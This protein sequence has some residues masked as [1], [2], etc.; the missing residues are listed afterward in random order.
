MKHLFKIV[1]L[2]LLAFACNRPSNFILIQTSMG[3]ITVELYDETPAHR[4]NFQ[5]LVAEG[6]YEG[7]LFHRVIEDFMIQGGDPDSKGA[8]SS[9]YLGNGG[10]GYTI[11]AELD[12]S[13][14]CFHKKGALAAART[15]DAANP[16]RVSSGSQFYIVSGRK[17]TES[18]ISQMERR[19]MM[20]TRREFFE[21]LS[22]PYQQ[23][24]DSLKAIEDRE[25]LKA[26]QKKVLAQAD[27]KLA[28][29]PDL[30]AMD[31]ERKMAYQEQGGTPHLDGSYTVFGQVIE[32]LDV[33]D[34]IAKAEANKANRPID[35]IIMSMK[36]VKK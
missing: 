16:E 7:L 30:Y 3:D 13:T 9:K 29:D 19:Q 26:I 17:Y 4:D 20:E 10:P 23:Q 36:F 8:A 28:A 32:G 24:I 15:S 31:V 33:V 25:G 18:E 12:A 35:D 34:A 21:E 14:R 2:S 11:T 5:K 22:K 6:F 27:A 1:A